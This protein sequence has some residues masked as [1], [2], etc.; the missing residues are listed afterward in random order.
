MT[1]PFL[2]CTPPERNSTTPTRPSQFLCPI[3][4]KPIPL[5]NA[6]ADENGQCIHEECYLLKLQLER[7][8]S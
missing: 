1:R 8:S 7:A 4:G 6:K 2:P 3:C 5:E